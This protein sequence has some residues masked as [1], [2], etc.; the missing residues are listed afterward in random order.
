MQLKRTSRTVLSFTG[1]SIRYAK[2]YG[3]HNSI[4]VAAEGEFAFNFNTFWDEP[5]TPQNSL[6]Q[7]LKAHGLGKSKAIIGLPAQWCLFDE[8][9]LPM[10]DQANLT[11]AITLQAQQRYNRNDRAFV[12]DFM[13]P[14]AHEGQ[15]SVTLGAMTL[16]HLAAMEYAFNEAALKIH[17]ILPTSL[18][19]HQAFG[20]TTAKRWQ[21][22]AWMHNDQ[23]ELFC[24]NQ[25]R[26]AGM[27]LLQ[28]DNQA[29]NGDLH[30][31]TYNSIKQQI[32]QDEMIYAVDSKSQSVHM[33]WDHNDDC[34]TRWFTKPT[35]ARQWQVHTKK[36]VGRNQTVLGNDLTVLGKLIFEDDELPLN[37]ANSRLEQKQ[38]QTTSPWRTR[39]ILICTLLLILAGLTVW[40]LFQLNRSITDLNQQIEKVE[41]GATRATSIIS[42]VK[43]ADHWFSTSPLYLNAQ[44]SVAIAFQSTASIWATHFTLKPDGMGLLNGAAVTEKDILGLIDRVKARPDLHNVKLL[45]MRDATSKNKTEKAYA[46]SFL[47][48]TKNE[49]GG[50][51]DESK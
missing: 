27:D 23:I 9:T 49:T 13:Q 26:Y 4:Q 42:M 30:T 46:I 40:D 20:S 47:F 28:L 41:N 1:Q 8:L 24:W 6:T 10:L 5:L 32:Q 39:I 50:Q 7:Q 11:H 48:S 3:S 45:Y 33:I 14:V 34:D 18:A 31:Q 17:S 29:T 36:R 25:K 38:K 19:L 15:W 12:C 16:A 44:R 51:A 37:F 35:D 43:R 21:Y 22:T 2:L